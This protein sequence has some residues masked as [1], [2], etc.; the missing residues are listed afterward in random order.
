M[1]NLGLI[2]GNRYSLCFLLSRGS[3]YPLFSCSISH[4]ICTHFCCV[5]YW[6]NPR[7]PQWT[8]SI[9][10]NAPFRTEMCTFLVWMVH[11]GI[12]NGIW[13]IGPLVLFY[14]YIDSHYS[15]AHIFQGCFTG[16]GTVVRL[17]TGT[18]VRLPQCLWRTP[19]EY[20]QYRL[21]E[22]IA[23]DYN[24]YLWYLTTTTQQPFYHS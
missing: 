9:P 20:G 2:Y 4:E 3:S 21:R 17:P 18:V 13:E 14:K 12:C 7:I 5:F 11:H 23:A 15:F 6:P 8:C 10:H 1:Q 16:T 19:K 24:Q 22:S